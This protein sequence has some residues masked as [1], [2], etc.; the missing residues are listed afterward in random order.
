MYVFCTPN[1]ATMTVI[2]VTWHVAVLPVTVASQELTVPNLHCITKCLI[3][4]IDIPSHSGSRITPSI[5]RLRSACAY[6]AA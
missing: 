6:R 3:H 1:R 5:K 2:I 4:T